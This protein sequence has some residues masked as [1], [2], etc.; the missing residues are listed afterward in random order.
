[1]LGNIEKTK[2]VEKEER[3]VVEFWVRFVFILVG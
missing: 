2:E 3:V 1:M